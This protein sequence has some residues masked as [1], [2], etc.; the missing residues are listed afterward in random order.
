MNR[1]LPS[2]LHTPIVPTAPLL[3]WTGIALC[4]AL[5]LG[6]RMSGTTPDVS[7]LITICERILDGETAYVDI[8]ETTPP[9]PLLLYMPGVAFARWL[10]ISPLPPKSSTNR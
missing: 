9:V 4:F 10:P 8:I 5:S 2:T 1:R 3:F 6:I 7:W